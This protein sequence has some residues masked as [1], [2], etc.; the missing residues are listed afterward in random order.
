[1][2]SEEEEDESQMAEMAEMGFALPCG[3]YIFAPEKK[4]KRNLWFYTPIS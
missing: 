2:S 4:R 1:L 3:M